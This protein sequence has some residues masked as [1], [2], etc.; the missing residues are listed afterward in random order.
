MNIIIGK[1]NLLDL[2]HKHIVLEL[3]TFHMLPTGQDVEAYCVVEN[4]P[5]PQLAEVEGMREL[6]AN[7]ISRY[8]EREWPYCLSA[9]EHLIGFW[10]QELDSFYQ[11]LQER[12][13]N[14]QNQDP[15]PAWDYRVLK[16]NQ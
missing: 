2:E 11:I 16:V 6:H 3:D 10:G 8:R 1:H 13:Q 14:Y 15:G 4:I 5:I 12:I 7:L 9:I